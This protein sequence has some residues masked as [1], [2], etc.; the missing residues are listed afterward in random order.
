MGAPSAKVYDLTVPP[1]AYPGRRLVV[2][3]H[4]RDV[5]MSIPSNKLAGDKIRF[6]IDED[7]MPVLVCGV[8]VWAGLCTYRR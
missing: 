3:V 1:G 7:G 5:A 2:R 4:G 8:R 6:K